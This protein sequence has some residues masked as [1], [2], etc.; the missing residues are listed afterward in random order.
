MQYPFLNDI[1]VVGFNI[2]L[3]L[4]FEHLHSMAWNEDVLFLYIDDFFK[5]INAFFFHGIGIVDIGI[6]R[7]FYVLMS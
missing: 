1:I 7:C 6:E 4:S 5:Y 2:V 3:L